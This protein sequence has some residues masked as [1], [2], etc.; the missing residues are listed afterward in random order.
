MKKEQKGALG[1][2]DN[3]IGA[4]APPNFLELEFPLISPTLGL[5]N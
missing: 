4:I 2:G 1:G 5:R 3:I